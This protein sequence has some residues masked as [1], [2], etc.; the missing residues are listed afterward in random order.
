MHFLNLGTVSASAIN[1]SC[2]V[3]PKTKG[4]L[5]SFFSCYI[6]LLFIG[7]TKIY[8]TSCS[9]LQRQPQ[10]RNHQYK[11]LRLPDSIICR[12]RL[13]CRLCCKFL[14]RRLPASYFRHGLLLAGHPSL[15]K[16]IVSINT[17]A[18]KYNYERFSFRE[19]DEVSENTVLLE[20]KAHFSIDICHAVNILQFH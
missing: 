16:Y 11:I 14:P 4:F 15:F 12:N 6:R 20:E 9:T 17:D 2:H 18:S 13:S 10:I 7:L 8:C 5:L 1:E 19:V 3:I